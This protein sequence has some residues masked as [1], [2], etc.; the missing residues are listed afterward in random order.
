M[1][2]DNN[3]PVL[4]WAKA[5]TSPEIYRQ[6]ISMKDAPPPQQKDVKLKPRDKQQTC[7]KTK[8]R[9]PT[10]RSAGRDLEHRKASLG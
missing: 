4:K 7:I 9:T 1:K 3:N 5:G 10:P 2:L 8:L 6:L